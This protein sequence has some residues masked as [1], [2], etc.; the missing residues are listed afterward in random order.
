[1]AQITVT[2]TVTDGSNGGVLPGANILEEGTNNGTATDGNGKYSITVS[3]SNA[4]LSFSFAGMQTQEVTVGDQ[5]VIDITLTQG[6]EIDEAVVTALGLT[7]SKRALGYAVSDVNGDDLRN[8][9]ES[10]VIQGLAAKAPGVVVTGSG[11]TPG[12][13]SKILIR[14]AGTFTGSNSPLIV[15]DGIP[16][17]NSTIQSTAGDNPFNSN[18]AGVNN[19]NRA[20]DLNPNDIES[21]TVLKGPAAA[22]LYGARAGNGAIVYTTKRGKIGLN[23]GLQ[24][25]YTTSLEASVVNKLPEFQSAYGGGVGGAAAVYADPGP[26]GLFFTADDVSAG[27]QQS[28]GPRLDTT[29]LEV[30]DNNGEFFETGLTFE[31]NLSVSTSN[32]KAAVR[33][34][35]GDLRQKGTVPNTNLN[36][37]SFRVNVDSKLTNKLS[38]SASGNFVNT[39]GTMA[40]NGSNLAGIMLGLLR[41]PNTFDL[42][43]YQYDN[44]FQ[45]SYFF[46]Y[47]NPYYTSLENPFTSNVNRFLG[48]IGTKYQISS[49]LSASYRL[50]VDAYAD[51]RKQIFAV[52]SFGDD[53][54]GEGQVNL[55]SLFS[56]RVYGDLLL[57]YN[58]ELNEKSA[59]NATLGNNFTKNKYS[60]NFSRGRTLTVPNFYNLSSASDL[61]T[62]NLVQNDNSFAF[63]A[64][65]EYEYDNFLFV[66]LTGRN[67]WSSTFELPTDDSEGKN[68]FFYPSASLSF[69]FTELMGESSWLD[70]GKVRLSR[71]KV[72]IAPIPYQTRNIYTQPTFTDGFTNG[73]GFPF[74]G[75][76]GF[77]QSDIRRNPKPS[78]KHTASSFFRI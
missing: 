12:S 74:G 39:Q 51:E 71:A 48:N 55:N 49:N 76:N 46:V 63:F 23:Q 14:G 10:N 1:M 9:Q 4:V 75:V 50:G 70:F 2:G 62:S 36:R 34:S 18:L 32:E 13:S 68:N 60:D 61:Y 16:I 22:A 42:T 5:T 57:N 28:W 66:N 77:S 37:T 56:T 11:G 73:L 29:N 69:V 35:I 78:W 45:R 38:V 44:G 31:N 43:D 53:I 21:V 67:E 58:K 52:S 20:L 7:K 59:I 65:V 25:S 33:M 47:D 64:N 30:Y 8:S 15:V 17:D 6:V 40:Q 54:G 27:T 3:N 41:T 26:D 72:G 24:A 19:S